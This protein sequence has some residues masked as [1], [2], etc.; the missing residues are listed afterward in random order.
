MNDDEEN[1]MCNDIEKMLNNLENNIDWV[2]D[3]RKLVENISK[4]NKN[5]IMERMFK[6]EDIF[7]EICR[8]LNKALFYVKKNQN[9]KKYY[10]IKPLTFSNT[11][12]EININN[13]NKIENGIDN[14]NKENNIY[15]K[16][17]IEKDKKIENILDKKLEI[18]I[19]NKIMDNINNE[20]K[21]N[22][23]KVKN[24]KLNYDNKDMNNIDNKNK[25]N[26]TIHNEENM[27]VKNDTK[28]N[29]KLEKQ[30]KNIKP[31]EENIVKQNL[32][33]IPQNKILTVTKNSE[34]KIDNKKNEIKSTSKK[35][36]LNPIIIEQNNNNIKEINKSEFVQSK[37]GIKFNQSSLSNN[38]E[39]NKSKKE[40]NDNLNKKSTNNKLNTKINTNS[41]YNNTNINNA[42]NN[43]NKNENELLS[44]IISDRSFTSYNFENEKYKIK[45]N[46]EIENKNFDKNKKEK[47]DIN[48][49]EIHE[50]SL[51]N[52][53]LPSNNDKKDIS[54]NPIEI[55][56]QIKKR[57]D[58]VNQ[59]I[60]I[61]QKRE[62][63]R[64]ML[65]EYYETDIID[66]LNS[67]ELD[68]DI[69]ESMFSTIEEIEKLKLRD[70][71]NEEDDE[72]SHSV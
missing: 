62:D 3:I 47:N 31:K 22:K 54:I 15:P 11:Y 23:Y 43:N 28:N 19:E 12:K 53:I 18:N 45:P 69:I 16:N 6:L 34:I 63:L 21:N 64:E 72:D 57:E 27:K 20:S 35:K 46:N 4:E 13:N 67:P 42:N 37:K 44:P 52:L 40:K 51:N 24:N 48:Y 61:L 29:K 41:R 66:L 71:I 39:L 9:E 49:N 65:S 60:L 2:I 5:T 55:A 58:K 8:I 59:L 70:E 30:N 25:N 7:R 17:E 68:T 10:N 36:S 1:N 38:T 50:T 33:N 14:N 26:K 32:N 56:E